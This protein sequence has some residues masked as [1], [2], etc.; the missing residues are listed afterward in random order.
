MGQNSEK[1]FKET[2][3]EEI[4]TYP[5][6][7]GVYLNLLDNGVWDKEKLRLSDIMLLT[8]LLRDIKTFETNKKRLRG[9]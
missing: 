5:D 3:V 9:E 2:I 8:D 1:T 4:L 6:S 7:Y